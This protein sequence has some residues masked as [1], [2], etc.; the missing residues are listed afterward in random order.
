VCAASAALADAGIELLDVLPACSV[1]SG[2]AWLWSIG[3]TLAS[4]SSL[5]LTVLLCCHATPLAC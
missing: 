2:S 3:R 5:T 4:A 1:V